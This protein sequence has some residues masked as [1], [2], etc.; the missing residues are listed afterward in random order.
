MQIPE[1]Y[2]KNNIIYRFL[3]WYKNMEPLCLSIKWLK[4]RHSQNDVFLAKYKN[5]MTAEK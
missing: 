3:K 1:T 5:I 4:Y 2:G